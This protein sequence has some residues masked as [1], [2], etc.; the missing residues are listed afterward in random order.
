MANIESEMDPRTNL[1]IVCSNCDPESSV[2]HVLKATKFRVANLCCSGE[3]RIIRSALA[4]L[5]IKEEELSINLIAR[6]IVVKHC[7]MNCCAPSEEICTI[8]NKKHLGVSIQEAS[9]DDESFQQASFNW[10]FFIL[11][12]IIWCFFVAGLVCHLL[13]PSYSNLSDLSMAFYLT[14]TGL[15]LIFIV[16]EAYISIIRRTIG[17]SILILIAIGEYYV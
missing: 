15:G 4:D 8:L 12:C 5:G 2:P 9:T 6:Y 7:V 14:S 13:Q 11:T 16:H 10:G 17:I 1:P 3:E